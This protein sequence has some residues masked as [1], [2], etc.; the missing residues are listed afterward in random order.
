MSDQPLVS[1]IVLAY[2]QEQFI[3]EAVRSAL[4]QTYGR[5][6]IVLS[7]DKSPDKTF[8]IIEQE[9]KRYKGPH[10]L[11][12][13]RNPA[14]LGLAGNLN[15]AVQLASGDLLVVQ[16]G[17]DISVPART[18]KLVQRWVSDQPRRDLVYSDVLRIAADGSVLQQQIPPLPM[19]TVEQ[20]IRG[21]W[22][23]AGGCAAAYSRSL[24]EKYGPLSPNVQYEDYVLTFRALVGAGCAYV[25]E[26]L[27]YYRVHNSSII[28]STA[29]S[30]KTRLAGAR[31]AKH[32]V[33]EAEERLRAWDLSEK[34]NPHLRG[35]LVRNLAHA[36]L[37]VRSSTGSRLTALGC[38]IRAVA[39]ARLR[40][41]W[42]FLRRDVLLKDGLS[43]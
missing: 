26:P 22:F 25:N 5:L 30:K 18:T 13:N 34:R 35:R 37:D 41:A 14:N 43:S 38:V 8:E 19:A 17:D 36:R 16:G 27:V 4:A 40:A 21:K 10:N 28:Q 12:L 9:A 11:V 42:T 6:E 15:R 32:A 7:D 2:R 31:W 20:V 24:F 39:S 3:R 33:A 23:I 29:Q 1:F